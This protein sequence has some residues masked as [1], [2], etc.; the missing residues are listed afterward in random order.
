MPPASEAH[1]HLCEAY[2]NEAMLKNDSLN[3]F[4]EFMSDKRKARDA[5]QFCREFH[6]IDSRFPSMRM[7]LVAASIWPK[8]LLFA[9]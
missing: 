1:D 6:F 4:N 3:L 8:S 9:K 7:F 5:I 2:G